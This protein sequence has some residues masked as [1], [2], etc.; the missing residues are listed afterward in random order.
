M[1]FRVQL[2]RQIVGGLD[3]LKTDVECLFQRKCLA[4]SRDKALKHSTF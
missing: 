3:P 4:K 2:C 1:C